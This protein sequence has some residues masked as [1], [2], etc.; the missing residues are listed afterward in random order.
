MSSSYRDANPNWV[1]TRSVA[2]PMVNIVD[3]GTPSYV[4]STVRVYV[5]FY[6]RDRD[7]S[8]GSDT[9]CRGFEGIVQ[10]VSEHGSWRYEPGSG[11]SAI[12]EPDG[13]PNC[14]P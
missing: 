10:L 6:A 9:R 12:V 2:N 11:L 1:S 5:K 8:E 7:P 3:I 14:H 4:G 13:D